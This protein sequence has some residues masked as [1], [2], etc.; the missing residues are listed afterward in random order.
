MHTNSLCQ[1]RAVWS[2]QVA[3]ELFT[4]VRHFFNTHLGFKSL[5]VGA[6]RGGRENQQRT[7]DSM[8]S[9]RSAF[10]EIRVQLCDRPGLTALCRESGSFHLDRCPLGCTLNSVMLQKW[11][12]SE[13]S[14]SAT[15]TLVLPP[16]APSGSKRQ[17]IREHVP[18]RAAV[19]I[20]TTTALAATQH[21]TF[22][23]TFEVRGI[24]ALNA[25]PKVQ[26]GAVLAHVSCT[27]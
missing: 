13:G 27:S 5:A 11:H 17:T 23:K 10:D 24:A 9:S 7:F 8:S 4:E 1:R 22:S 14:S 18:Q 16:I 21:E 3:E 25:L 20:T 2:Q 19:R 15:E 12:A 26:L 6:A